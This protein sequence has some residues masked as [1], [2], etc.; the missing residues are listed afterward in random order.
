MN[1]EKWKLYCE[2]RLLDLELVQ[3][4]YMV[5]L[6]MIADFLNDAENK[7]KPYYIEL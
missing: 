4:E 5:L 6:W 2:M 3:K 7:L 1:V